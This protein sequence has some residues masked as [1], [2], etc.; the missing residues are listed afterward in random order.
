M[1]A[2]EAKYKTGDA[3]RVWSNTDSKWLNGVVRSLQDDMV[4]AEYAKDGEQGTAKM[5]KTLPMD[6][7]DIQLAAPKAAP[8][9][10]APP[11]EKRTDFD[12]IVAGASLLSAISGM[13]NAVAILEMSS[14]VAHH[15][16][17]ASHFGRLLG[18]DGFRFLTLMVAYVVG[19]GSASFGDCDGDAIFAGRTSDGLLGVAGAVAAGSVLKGIM[20]MRGLA[21]LLWAFSQGLQNGITSRFHGLALR[22]THV[23]GA[24]TDAGLVLGQWVQARYRGTQPPSLRK[25]TLFLSCVL[26]F[27]AGG[28][29]VSFL[30]MILG[31]LAALAPAAALAALASGRV[32]LATVM[33]HTQKHAVVFTEQAKKHAEALKKKMAEILPPPPP[34]AAALAALASGRVTLATV[35]EHTQKHAVVFTEQA[36][37]HAEALKKKM[38]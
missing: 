33:E 5:V 36:K 20:G 18:R 29:I 24:L 12:Q 14:T 13:V 8:A 21:L 15:T 34:R 22:T 30:W 38:A 32:T 35:M 19:A 10:P 9:A 17:N 2:V 4:V 23:T 37:K 7:E 31:S 1:A 27:A 11:L 25:P 28:F 16:G 3:V 6:S 26:S